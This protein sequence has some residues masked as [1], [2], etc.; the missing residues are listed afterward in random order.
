[1]AVPISLLLENNIE[2]A[3]GLAID[4]HRG[5][6]RKYSGLP[7]VVHVLEVAS[8]CINCESYK[9][10][11]DAICAAYL[12]DVIEDC[13]KSHIRLIKDLLPA[14]VL[15]LIEELTNYSKG[16]KA[17]RA[18]RKEMDRAHLA[19]VSQTAKCIKMIDRT[20][21][22]RDF[23]RVKDKVS[24]D[25]LKKYTDESILL[26]DVIRNANDELA[27]DLFSAIADFWPLEHK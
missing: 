21:N 26:H 10:D 7:Y 16:S 25:F 3:I 4:A 12:H 24:P 14:E 11:E 17:P 13:D 8:L 9:F 2:I 23:Y 18:V 6:K 27:Q 22:L 5:Q 1:M 15:L 20:C 19:T